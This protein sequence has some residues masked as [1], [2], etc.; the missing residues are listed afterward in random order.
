MKSRLLRNPR[1]TNLP[2]PMNLLLKNL[3]LRRL[4]LK[5][6]RPLKNLP[7]LKRP[8]WQNH[9]LKRLRLKDSHLPKNLL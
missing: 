2:P 8:L 9:L 5:N 4:S 6:P 1:P 7:P 3:L